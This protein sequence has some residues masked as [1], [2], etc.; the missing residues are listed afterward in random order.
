MARN[1]RQTGEPQYV[2]QCTFT[3]PNGAGPSTILLDMIAPQD[4]CRVVSYA[5][6]VKTAGTGGATATLQ[7]KA[8]ANAI[9]DTITLGANTDAA[10]TYEASGEGVRSG[11]FTMNEGQQLSVVWTLVASTNTTGAVYIISVTF[12]G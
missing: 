1:R 3:V 12:G 5:V 7:L 9:G 11:T 8:G 2:E 10:G 4:R 6:T